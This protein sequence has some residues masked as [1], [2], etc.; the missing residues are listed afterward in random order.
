MEAALSGDVQSFAYWRLYEGRK[1]VGIK[2]V[3]CGIGL[4]P[5]G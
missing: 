2:A 4:T 1:A 3:E 5:V